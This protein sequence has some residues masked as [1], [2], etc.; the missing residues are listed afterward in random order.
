MESNWRFGVWNGGLDPDIWE[1]NT[2]WH[3]GQQGSWFMRGSWW[4]G[5]SRTIELFRVFP[6][7]HEEVS[8]SGTEFTPG[9]PYGRDVEPD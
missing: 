1:F 9:F 6:D 5:T 7:G 3:T 4:D 2:V 8:F